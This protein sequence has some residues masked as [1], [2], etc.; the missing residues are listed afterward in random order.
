MFRWLNVAIALLWSSTTW[1]APVTL[2]LGTD[3][4]VEVRITDDGE[5]EIGKAAKAGDMNALD[6]KALVE[7]TGTI[8]PPDAKTLPPQIISK[9]KRTPPP[10]IAPGHLRMSLRDV[11]GKSPHDRLLVIENGYTK[12]L[13]YTAEL[14]KGDRTQAT[15][16]CWVLPGKRGYEHWP[17]P[18]DRIELGTLTLVDWTEANGI[19][20]E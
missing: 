19:P 12:A 15:D 3:E 14:R 16:V 8:V 1:A 5:V 4:T 10:P 17:Y 6:R 9:D 2:T 7:L 13:R 20:C 18:F 11:P